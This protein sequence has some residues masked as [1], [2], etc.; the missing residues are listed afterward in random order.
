MHVNNGSLSNW[1]ISDEAHSFFFFVPEIFFFFL[2]QPALTCDLLCPNSRTCHI[3]NRILKK[4]KPRRSTEM[5][6]IGWNVVGICYKTA[7]PIAN[8]D[9]LFQSWPWALSQLGK[10]D[11]SSVN[12]CRWCVL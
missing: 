1:S 8:V 2:C 3:T 9:G 12:R 6:R 11:S 4:K 10:F 5:H 7:E